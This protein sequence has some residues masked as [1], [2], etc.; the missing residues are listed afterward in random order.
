M[1]ERCLRSAFISP[2][3]APLRNSARVVACFSSSVM[4]VAGAIQLAE[5]PPDS[6]TSTRSSPSAAS[7]SASARSVRRDP[8]LIR[9]RMAGLDHGNVPGRTAIAVAGDGEAGEPLARRC[10]RDN[11]V[12]RLASSRPRPCRRQARRAG[13]A[14]AVPAGSAAGTATGARRRPRCG[15][16]IRAIR[17]P[18]VGHRA[19][20]DRTMERRPLAPLSLS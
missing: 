20:R 18:S 3:A 11:A 13:R 5:A 12:P 15:T 1:R 7:A 17:A 9:H 14:A 10:G 4:P 8:R 2:M 16:A 19:S 6:S